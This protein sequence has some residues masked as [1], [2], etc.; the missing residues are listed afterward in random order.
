MRGQDLNWTMPWLQNVK[1]WGLPSGHD[2][3]SPLDCKL[4]IGIACSPISDSVYCLIHDFKFLIIFGV[5]SFLPNN[6]IVFWSGLTNVVDF[7]SFVCRYAPCDYVT[8]CCSS[9]EF[10]FS[11]SAGNTGEGLYHNSQWTKLVAWIM[12]SQAAACCREF[13]ARTGLPHRTDPR[14][15]RFLCLNSPHMAATSWKSMHC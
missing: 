12:S 1:S 5:I 15:E 3:D 14:L 8:I 13:G 2:L 4:S 11:K 9:G 6:R 10:I 7:L